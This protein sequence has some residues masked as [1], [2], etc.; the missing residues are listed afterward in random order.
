MPKYERDGISTRNKSRTHR[1]HF[2]R[3]IVAKKMQLP[4]LPTVMY[5]TDYCC[6]IHASS[7]VAHSSLTCLLPL[8]SRMEKMYSA[9]SS[10]EACTI[11]YTEIANSSIAPSGTPLVFT[12]RHALASSPAEPL[13]LVRPRLNRRRMRYFKLYVVFFGGGGEGGETWRCIERFVG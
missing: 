4:L 9:R 6:T 13:R 5:V 8:V 1:A 11:M 7:R 2:S 10:G 3:F 12:A